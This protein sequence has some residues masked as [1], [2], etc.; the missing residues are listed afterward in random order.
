[1]VRKTAQIQSLMDAD[2]LGHVRQFVQT[3]GQDVLDRALG[4]AYL[5]ETEGSFSLEGEVPTADKAQAFV[6]LLKHAG[7]PRP[8]DEDTLCEWQRLSITNELDKAFEYRSEQNRLQKGPGAAGVRYVPPAPDQVPELMDGL[9]RLAND[10]PN[11]IDPLVHAAVVSFGFVFIHPFMDGNGRLSRFLAH[12]CLGQSGALPRA[13]V[14]PI[15]VAMK[16]H[17]GEYL[18]ALT[19]FSKPARELCDVRWASGEEYDFR[20]LDTAQEAFRYMDLTAPTEFTLHMAQVALEKDL[21]HETQWLMQFD[22]VFN[23]VKAQHDIRDADLSALITIAFHN[24][25][26]ISNKKRKAFAE[27]VPSRVMNAIDEACSGC[28]QRA[29]QAGGSNDEA[30]PAS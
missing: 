27:R 9:L 15:S 6:H 16:R 19:S 20:W 12:H 10:R 1:V 3:A 2:I 24:G 25:G 5:S 26:V 18:R 28:L 7:D 21:L 30:L 4:W 17:E 29:A 22:Q 23:Q 11:G 13:V 14:L 8:L